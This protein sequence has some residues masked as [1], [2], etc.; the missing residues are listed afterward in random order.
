[1]GANVYAETI[2]HHN[3]IVRAALADHDGKE[4]GVRGDSFFAVFST[5]SSALAATLQIQR[6]LVAFEWP[7]GEQLRVRVGVHAGEVAETSSGL[8]GYEIH[9][10][11]RI[12]D[13]GYGEQILLSS[14]V[15]GLVEDWLEDGASLRSLGTH[16][17]K[18]LGRPETIFQ[19]V[20]DGLRSDFPPLRSLD[21]P[22][23]PN[24]LPA[25][26]SPFIGR[27]EEIGEVTSLVRGSRMVTL[28]GAGGCGK[29]RLALQAAAELLDGSGEGVWHVELAAVSD[30]D[31]VPSAI[32]DALRVAPKA[33]GSM[34]D[35]LVSVLKDQYLLLVLDNC[36]HLLDAVSALID[37]VGR[38][39]PRVHVLATSREPLGVGGEEVYRVRSMSLPEDDAR[40]AD[41]VIASDSVRLFVARATS[42]DK[43]FELVDENAELVASICRRLDGIPLALELAAARLSTM[44]LPDLYE[45]LD[46]RLRLLTGGSRTALSR[47]QTLA[48]TV[49]WSYDSLDD[50]TRAVLCRA[51][52]F[53][54][55]FDLQAAEAVCAGDDVATG[56]VAQVIGTLVAKSLVNSQ[57]GPMTMRY[58]LFETIRQ[59]AAEK[60]VEAHGVGEVRTL[61]ARHAAHFLARGESIAPGLAYGPEKVRLLDEIDTEWGN[62]NA[63]LAYWASDPDRSSQVLRLGAAIAP[64]MHA[65]YQ[66]EPAEIMA[67]ALERYGVG[68]LVRARALFWAPM[69]GPNIA[70]VSELEVT[71]RMAMMAEAAGLARELGD[72]VLESAA[73]AILAR[74]TSAAIDG[75][76]EQA[77]ELVEIAL[78]IAVD[79]DL[80]WPRG[81]ALLSKGFILCFHDSVR[82]SAPPSPEGVPA[83]EE[84][85]DWFLR[86]QDPVFLARAL[87]EL[88]L[89]SESGTDLRRTRVLKEQSLRV[90]EEVGD[91]LMVF[92][93]VSDLS[94]LAFVDGEPELA[95]TYARRS[96][97]LSRRLGLAGWHTVFTVNNLACCA[98]A[99]LEFERAASLLGGV[100]SLD[101]QLPD[102]SYQWDE[103]ERRAR[104][105]AAAASR[106][107]LGGSEYDRRVAD[108][109]AMSYAQLVNLA[110]RR[111]PL[112]A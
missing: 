33:G 6:D 95:E 36:E 85:I 102:R 22:D 78:R 37:R 14:A 48:A 46:E 69:L 62:Y 64:Y 9:K 80:A 104:A 100:D 54:D 34:T 56:D 8:I 26:L 19:L 4:Q 47:Q 12:A 99:A 39:C 21:S 73:I 98:A 111:T 20:A 59:F 17:L 29:T 87:Q 44:A 101:S 55:G 76:K 31:K 25:S 93:T 90:A 2:E 75:D 40:R 49:A 50:T 110:L 74:L 72:R 30:G 23:M 67:S 53:V 43:T 10:A 88:S 66:L 16:R 58:R 15:A 65:R 108:G 97:M 52:V 81:I 84:S 35:T 27:G 1:M 92:Y 3:R 96:L 41:E 5:P 91:T 42:L 112:P 38:D 77:L 89:A 106:A 28:A 109:R 60:L 24:N 57:R 94:H 107:A 79:G 86:A 51:S 13:V 63:A 82:S 103:S 45:R 71:R 7:G 61:R 70:T 11:A 32:L 105:D 18:D 68:D 83:L